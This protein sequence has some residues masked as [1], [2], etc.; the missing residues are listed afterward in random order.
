[1]NKKDAFNKALEINTKLMFTL[2]ETL[3]RIPIDQ[4][5]EF[6]D[7][8][9]TLTKLADEAIDL[10]NDSPP[11]NHLPEQPSR[12]PSPPLEGPRRER[13][14]FCNWCEKPLFD[15][16]VTSCSS[17]IRFK[18]KEE[19]LEYREGHPEELDEEGRLMRFPDLG[20]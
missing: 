18:S 4:R 20:S 2:F 7:V 15:E 14:H 1:M 10:L 13:K 9:N 5:G 6:S 12:S 19:M 17:C 3:C 8:A 11:D 16:T